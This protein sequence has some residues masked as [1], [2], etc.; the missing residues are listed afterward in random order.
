MSRMSRTSHLLAAAIL[1]VSIASP[2]WAQSGL[3]RGTVVN[4]EGE[5]LAGVQVTVTSEQLASFRQ[6]QLT[7]EDGEFSVRFLSNQAQ[8]VFQ[9]QLE[10]P[11]YQ[12]LMQE[13][14]PSAT[15][16]SREEFVLEKSETQVVEHHGD[17]AA[18]VTGS[19]NAAIEA[20]NAGLTA[21]REGDLDTARGKLEEAVA[22]DASLGP[23]HVA[24][25]QVLLDQKEYAAAVES[26]EQALALDIGRAEALRVK[27]QALRAL[28]KKDEAEA[29]ASELESVED[30]VAT[31]R[32]LYNE[33]SEA[34]QADDLDTALAKFQEAAELDPSLVDAHHA[35][36]TV[37]LGK[38]NAEEAAAAAQKALGLGSDDIRTL[39]VLYDAYQALGRLEELTEIA[40]R[41]AAIDP[42][43]G[44]AKLLEQAAAHW[45]AG[46]TEQ[47]V[48]LARQALAIDSSLAKARYFIGLDH[49]SKGENAQ[50]R[51]E[52]QTFID[53]A[54]DDPEAATAKEML[55]YI[56]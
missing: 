54:P 38:G 26:A 37:Q 4:V 25:S 16:Q 52:L 14:S 33:G 5:P 47:A 19:T 32:R 23:A 43:F 44:G 36:A 51:Q 10:K 9:I 41:L 6:T 45:N 46:Q 22:A 31:A 28:G 8:Y 17:L 49:L 15:R 1:L 40:P 30:A 42:D 55:A 56:E 3:L 34:F 48:S 21:Q 53:Q 39:R 2:S 12:S 27:Y 13:V 29:V 11:G 24:L 50:A 18:V 7:D 20:F 35:V